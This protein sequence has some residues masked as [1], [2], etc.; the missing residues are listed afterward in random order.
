MRPVV[1]RE[2]ATVVDA[3]RYGGG[4]TLEALDV[5]DAVFIFSARGAPSEEF[6][7]GLA[8]FAETY[9][10]LA[11]VLTG[12]IIDDWIPVET[13]VIASLGASTQV[14]SAV[15]QTLAG[16]L[17]PSGSLDGLLPGRPARRRPPAA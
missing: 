14:A 13:P 6:S 3:A 12:W 17:S 5:E 16:A 1:Q 9:R 7:L 15:A 4:S 8:A 2:R 11:V 10:P